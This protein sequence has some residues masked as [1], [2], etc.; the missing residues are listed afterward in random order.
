MRCG[1]GGWVG[2]M[3]SVLTDRL[4]MDGWVGEMASG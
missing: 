4:G 2:K 3:A 1:M